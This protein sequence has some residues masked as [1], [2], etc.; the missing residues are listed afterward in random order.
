M[1]GVK[2]AAGCY[3]VLVGVLAALGGL[4]GDGRYY[5]AAVVL[6]LP[7]GL[8]AVA[9]VYLLRGLVTGVGGLFTDTVL[10]DGSEPGWLTAVGV[11]GNTVLFAA[12]AA[13]M[14]LLAARVVRRRRGAG[15]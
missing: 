9:G 12:A 10:P 7:V 4:G 3:V 2:G 15:S 11:A 8:V 1:G 6:T 13:T 5:L 14:V